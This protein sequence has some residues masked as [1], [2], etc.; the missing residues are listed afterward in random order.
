MALKRFAM[1]FGM[2]TDLQGADYTKAAVRALKDALW[3]NSLTM[4]PAC[5]A[6]RSPAAMSHSQLGLSA[7]MASNRPSATRQR[8]HAMEDRKACRNGGAAPPCQ[9]SAARL[10]FAVNK[11]ADAASAVAEARIG[12]PFMVAGSCT[13]AA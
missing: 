9:C 7:S 5:R 4:A 11:V 1:E 12:A 8:R 13:V 10:P 2:G 6:I 3:H